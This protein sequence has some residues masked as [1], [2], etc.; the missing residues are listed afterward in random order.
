MATKKAT[1]PLETPMHGIRDNHSRGSVADFLRV[2]R[3][4]KLTPYRRPKLTP[5]I[6]EADVAQQAPPRGFTRWRRR[7][8]AQRSD[9]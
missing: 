5:L 9:D 8:R 2:N 1:T 3:R 6:V 7:L 4:S